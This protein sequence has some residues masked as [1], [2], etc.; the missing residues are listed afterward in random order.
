[1]KIMKDHNIQSP[2]SKYNV[3]YI[4]KPLPSFE[5]A[6]NLYVENLVENPLLGKR[7][8]KY[9]PKELTIA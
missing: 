1:M 4:I 6:N 8:G 3:P 5:D 7:Y 2:L 9:T